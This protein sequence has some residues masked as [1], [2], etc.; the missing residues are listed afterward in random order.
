MA[1]QYLK[2]V[3]T[4]FRN[5]FTKE[6]EYASQMLNDLMIAESEGADIDKEAYADK[7]EKCMEKNQAIP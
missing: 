1:E 3:R 2:A 7:L 4:R 6:N 5:T